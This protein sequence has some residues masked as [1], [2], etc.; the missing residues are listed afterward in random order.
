MV[1]M[2]GGRIGLLN[3]EVGKGSTFFFTLPLAQ[4]EVIIEMPPENTNVIL[5]ID[6]D[7]QVISLYERYLKPQGYQVIALTNPREA[8]ERA[9]QLKPYAITLDIMM[10]E[11][12][13][14]QVLQQLKNDPGTRDIPIVI[15]SI[16]EDEEKGY[17]LGAA[18][19]LVKPF[20]Q[21]DLINTINRVNK[22][23]QI[24]QILV[25]DDDPKDA[26]LVQKMLED[27]G[28]FQVVVAD[29]G[30]NGWDAMV[31]KRP[32]IVILDLFMPD[33]DGFTVLGNMRSSPQL[34]DLPVIVLTG[35]DLTVEQHA[36]MVK[37]GQHY[38]TKGLLRERELLNTLDVA[39]RKIRE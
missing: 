16:L 23:G 24:H 27:S 17:N 8:V 4:E 6:D 5:A 34:M 31:S 12:D 30:K 36:Q 22:N 19:Y 29:G 9:K 28:K 10:P 11:V 7:A 20:L 37:L 3:S 1:E 18:D 35:A 33:M 14:W 38:L 15:C 32:D 26:R 13:G 21:E 39:L 25:I 2:H